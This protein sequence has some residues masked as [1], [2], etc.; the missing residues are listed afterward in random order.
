MVVPEGNVAP[1][2]KPPVRAVATPGQLSVAT[3]AEY[4]TGAPQPEV[5]D[6]VEMFDGQVMTGSSMSTTVT[7]NEQLVT[8]LEA[9][10]AENATVV[11]PSG[12]E[13]PLAGPCV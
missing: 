2:G 12:K 5:V 6:T 8:L 4:V 3:G 11:A 1:E 7:V 13:E 10:V 9:S